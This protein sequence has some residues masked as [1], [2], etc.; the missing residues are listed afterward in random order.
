MTGR[1]SLRPST[2]ELGL[3]LQDVGR[4]LGIVRRI[5]L[6]ALSEDIEEQDGALTGIGPVF[7]DILRI[8]RRWEASLF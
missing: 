8:D 5:V 7:D 4:R 1:G 3:E 2:D 6:A